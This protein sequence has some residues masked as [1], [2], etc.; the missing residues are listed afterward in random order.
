MARDISFL[1]SN[2]V[3]IVAVTTIITHLAEHQWEIIAVRIA[4]AVSTAQRYCK[5]FGNCTSCKLT[6]LCKQLLAS[7]RRQ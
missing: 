2:T 7:L 4:I 3:N 6:L 1:A 5:R